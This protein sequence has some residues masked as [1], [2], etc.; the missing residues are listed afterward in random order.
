MQV[1]ASGKGSENEH[2]TIQ[3]LQEQMNKQTEIPNIILEAWTRHET[4]NK[5][6][7]ELGRIKDELQAVKEECQAANEECQAA[8]TGCTLASG[9][10]TCHIFESAQA[11]MHALNPEFAM[12]C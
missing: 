12:L 11:T 4:H 10:G 2:G 7:A 9:Q 3:T 6:Q 1:R 8:R 5:M